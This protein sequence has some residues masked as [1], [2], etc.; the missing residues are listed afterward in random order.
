[1]TLAAFVAALAVVPAC[2]IL[3]G[4]TTAPRA[5]RVIVEGQGPGPF[6]LVSSNQFLRTFDALGTPVLDVVLADTT[7]VD[8]GFDEEFELGGGTR[9]WVSLSR[10]EG[11]LVSPVVSMR[12]VVRGEALC[13]HDSVTLADD[14]LE[15]LFQFN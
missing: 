14:P 8:I 2:S 13:T 11:S 12:L 4:P 7:E 15:C 3:D 5:A 1:M 6:V 10:P 9:I